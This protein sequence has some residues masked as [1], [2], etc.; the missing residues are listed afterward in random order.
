MEREYVLRGFV[1]KAVCQK[2]NK[3]N[4]SSMGRTAHGDD[5]KKPL[6]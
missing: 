6:L 4:F 5:K 2:K 3:N 1:Y